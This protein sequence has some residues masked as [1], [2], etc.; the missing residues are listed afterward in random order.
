MKIC[1]QKGASAHALTPALSRKRE[2]ESA[3]SFRRAHLSPV[4]STSGARRNLG[5]LRNGGERRKD[6][7]SLRDFGSLNNFYPCES[8]KIRVQK[9]VSARALTPA[10]SRKREKGSA[11]L[12]R[13]AHLPPVH[14]DERSEEKSWIATIKISHRLTAVRNDRGRRKDFGSLK[15]ALSPQKTI[16]LGDFRSKEPRSGELSCSQGGLFQAYGADGF[17]IQAQCNPIPRPA[18]A[19]APK[20][21]GKGR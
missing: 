4:I 8:V 16:F 5:W 19:L 18:G 20:R 2:R 13:R 17:I 6:F 14:F 3:P 11:P 9:G 15:R 7:R 12:F 1:V 21:G 10:L